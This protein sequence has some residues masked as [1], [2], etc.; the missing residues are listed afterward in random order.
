MPGNAVAPPASRK[1]F[2]VT[3]STE[4]AIFHT[5]VS[6]HGYVKGR[7]KGGNI[8]ICLFPSQQL[9]YK[10]HCYEQDCYVCEYQRRYVVWAFCELEWLPRLCWRLRYD[11]R[12]W[13]RN[14]FNRLVGFRWRRCC[15]SATG[16][17]P[18]KR[19]ILVAQLVSFKV[20]LNSY[21]F[22]SC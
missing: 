5:C 18:E 15:F 8:K 2:S 12:R 7:I 20:C 21:P 19:D 22:D 11:R 4:T 3:A 13:R 17:F 10:Q 1:D 14:Y 16:S 6:I 9:A